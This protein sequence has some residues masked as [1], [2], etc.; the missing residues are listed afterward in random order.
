MPLSGTL[1]NFLKTNGK[2]GLKKRRVSQNL[3]RLAIASGIPSSS[4]PDVACRVAAN[5]Y[6][7]RSKGPL[8]SRIARFA[9][10]L[11]TVRLQPQMKKYRSPWC[12]S[13]KNHNI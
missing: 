5:A 11:L 2:R 9:P 10:D 7:R 6:P 1:W 4:S 12:M 8:Y 13:T 3:Q